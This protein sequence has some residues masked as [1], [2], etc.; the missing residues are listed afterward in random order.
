MQIFQTN[1]QEAVG[2]NQAFYQQFIPQSKMKKQLKIFL[3]VERPPPWTSAIQILASEDHSE[4]R[5][6]LSN[7]THFGLG[8][9]LEPFCPFC[10]RIYL[11]YTA[12]FNLKKQQKVQTYDLMYFTLCRVYRY[13]DGPRKEKVDYK[14]PTGVI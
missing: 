9:Q 4:V 2:S 5:H 13:P 14:P 8:T 11:I 7:H 1:T 10:T 6:P 12:F 3:Q